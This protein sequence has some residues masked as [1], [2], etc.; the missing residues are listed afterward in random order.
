[1]IRTF[2]QHAVRPADSLS[3]RWDFAIEPERTEGGRLPAAYP[4]SIYVP[5]A[6]EL[7]PGLE[8]YRGRGWVRTEVFTLPEGALRLVFGGV[9]HTATVF[10]DGEEAG[11]HYDAYTPWDVVVAG[12][13]P[14]EHELVVEVDNSF[15]AHSA[16]HRDNDYYTYGG[17]TRPVEIQF[18][19]EVYIDKLFATPR[20]EGSTWALD[21]RVRLRNWSDEPVERKVVVAVADSALELEAV[22]VEPGAAC[23]VEGT[24]EGL[25]V[26]A[27]SPQEPALY[28]AVAL[29]LDEE[30]A[31]DDLADRIGFRQVEVRGRELLLNGQPIRLRG[32]NRHEQHPHFGSALPEEAMVADLERL[33]DQGGNFLRTAHYPNDLRFLDLCD[34]MGIC[35]WEES[36]ARAVDFGHPRFRDQIAAATTEMVEWHHN[37]PCVLIWG[38]LNECDSVS[39]PGREEHR[40]VLELIRRLDPSRPVTFASNKGQRDRCLDLVDIVAWNRY[41]AWYGGGPD[42][43]QPR[44]EE[45]L[46]WL[47]SEHSGARD[48][49]LILSEFGAGA[50]YGTRDPGEARWS[51]EYQAEALDEC[52]R[53]YLHHPDVVGAAIWQFA[54]CRVCDGHW[55]DRPRT[56]NNKGTLDEYRRP[57]LAYAVVKRRMLEALSTPG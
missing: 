56:M 41:D 22:T 21:V 30:G 1:M 19:P 17:I 47:R 54:D 31:V 37:R 10:V 53:V 33:R 45:A 12:L 20:R 51:E 27:W 35:L 3:G 32:Y 2:A 49:P 44:L 39:E 43:V 48:K 36:H 4:R 9:S 6:W 8:G 15:G 18:V 40:R 24:L 28:E 29:L 16:L 13:E 52:L 5:S 7:L 23:E 11:G 25:D 42:D 55:R 50:L 34:E 14:G 46:Q 26:V 38:C 57:K